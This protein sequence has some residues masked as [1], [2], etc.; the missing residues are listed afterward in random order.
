LSGREL[1]KYAAGLRRL[2]EDVRLIERGV[3]EEFEQIEPES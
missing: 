1:A 3:E 2:S